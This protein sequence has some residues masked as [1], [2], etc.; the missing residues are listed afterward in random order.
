VVKGAGID[1]ALR[2]CS[3]ADT[4]PIAGAYTR[5]EQR[6]GTGL[7]ESVMLKDRNLVWVVEYVIGIVLLLAVMPFIVHPQ[8]G[9]SEAHSWAYLLFIACS[10][11][12]LV[13]S[14]SGTRQ[15]MKLSERI[16]ELEQM[17]EGQRPAQK[18]AHNESGQK[19]TLSEHLVSSVN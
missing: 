3:D 5:T 8:P 10:G 11:I 17:L 7:K 9:W 6:V 13:S 15:C 18:Q 12:T 19:R 4:N 16:K 1:D 14:A 2:G